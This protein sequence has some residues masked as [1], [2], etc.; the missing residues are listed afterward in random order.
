MGKV[1]DNLVSGLMSDLNGHSLSTMNVPSGLINSSGSEY[2]VNSA[3]I[4]IPLAAPASKINFEV[5]S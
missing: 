2:A 4:N 5:S 1:F 3:P